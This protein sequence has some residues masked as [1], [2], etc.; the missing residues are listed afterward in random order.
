MNKMRLLLFALVSFVGVNFA[1]A[2]MGAQVFYRYG[3][4][5]MSKDRGG[6]IFTDT[7]GATT[8]NDGKSGWNLS[9]GLD[10][11]MIKE[12]GP[13]DLLGEIMVD[14]AHYSKNSVTQTTS[15]L[16]G[17][18]A[19]SEITV[20]GLQVVVAPKY[21]VGTLLEG[22]LRPWVIPVGLAFLVNSPPSNDTTYLD[23]GYHV[24]AGVEYLLMKELSVGADYRM[25]FA[26]KEPGLDGSNSS[27]DLYVGVNF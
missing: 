24:G 14:Y 5:S 7:G 19:K 10:I 11:P 6:Q 15:V 3:M 2:Q 20:S 25:T 17:G 4:A 9:A 1:Q 26:A 13:G 27:V 22:K 18:S 21:R 16:T 12:I 23:I 8:K